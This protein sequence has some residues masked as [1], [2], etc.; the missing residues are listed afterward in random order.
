MTF[1]VSG[2]NM[3]IGEALR[4]RVTARVEEAL[5][6]Y[7]DGA[8]SGHVTVAR[9]GFGYRTECVLHLSSGITLHAEGA[10]AEAYASADDAATHLEKRLRRYKRRL[11]DHH[12]GRGGDATVPEAP[13]YVIAAPPVEDEGQ[14]NGEY[15]PV[16]IAE[17][18]TGLRQLS[19]GEAVLDL[20]LSGAPVLVFRHA[21]HGR[22]N[23][24]YRRADGNI[25]WIDTPASTATQ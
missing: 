4:T 9:D 16:I 25:G 20:D 21:G 7:F 11:K 10:A 22:V 12:H 13:S 1:R 3:D 5:S 17:G 15:H 19:V 23:V 14:G 6:K 24:V 18:T 2:Q 8:A